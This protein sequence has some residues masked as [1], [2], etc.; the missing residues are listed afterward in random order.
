MA[1]H[2]I[3]IP[4]LGDRLDP[5][6]RLALQRWRGPNAQVTLVAMRW[7]DKTETYEQ[8]YARIAEVIKRS[9]GQKII[10]VG[11][12]AGGAMALL[13][14]SRHMEQVSG[15]VTIC[16]YNHGASDIGQMYRRRN[17]AL[18]SLLL[19]TD[20]IVRQLSSEARQRVTVMYSDH[21]N[22]VTAKH[23]RI[24]GTR[25]I[26]LHKPGHFMN[27]GRVLARG[28]KAI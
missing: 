14:F 12:S 3:Y 21:D 6:R 9:D 16:G 4:G 18:H 10:L 2:Y 8:K 26:V 23:S 17:P 19:K 5:L 13:A 22:T 27:I 20:E 28:P 24:N 1:K 25:E 15:V 11:E 7:A